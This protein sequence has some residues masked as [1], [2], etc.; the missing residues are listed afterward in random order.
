MMQLLL[1]DGRF[2]DLADLIVRGDRNV[3]LKQRDRSAADE[4]SGF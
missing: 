2:D 4:A 3:F 1:F